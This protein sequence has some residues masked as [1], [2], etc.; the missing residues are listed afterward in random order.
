M[1]FNHWVRRKLRNR[2]MQGDEPTWLQRHPRRRYYVAAILSVPAWIKGVDLLRVQ[3]Q[4][5]FMTLATG[6]EHVMDHIVPL[7]HPHVCGL[8]VPWNIQVIPRAYNGHKS[9]H[10]WPDAW[11]E[12]VEFAL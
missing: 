8:T 6:I 7:N 10:W 4:R 3:K 2:L 11:F 12:Q 1:S 9:N 5:D